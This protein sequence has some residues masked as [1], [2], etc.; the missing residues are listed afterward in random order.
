MDL[1]LSCDVFLTA[2]Y[3]SFRDWIV[4]WIYREGREG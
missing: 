3:V 4:E 2:L 1:A